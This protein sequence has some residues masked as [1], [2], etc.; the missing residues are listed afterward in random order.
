MHA[1]DRYGIEVE[2]RQAYSLQMEVYIH[3]AMSMKTSE[4]DNSLQR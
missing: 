2:D 3:C 4:D 1:L